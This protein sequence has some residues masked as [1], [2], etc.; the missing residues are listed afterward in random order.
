MF[1]EPQIPLNKRFWK[2]S[3]AERKA[4]EALFA[5]EGVR[6]RCLALAGLAPDD[7]VRVVDAA[8]W[9]KGCSS[10]G[11]LRY[12][13]LLGF[14]EDGDKRERHALVD[15]KEAVESVAPRKKGAKMPRDPAAR[16]V[17]GAC[18]LSPNLG[19]RMIPARLLGKPVVMRELAPQDL[20]IEIEQF[21]RAEAVQAAAYLAFIVGVAHARQLS[22]AERL[23]WA[24]KVTARREDNLDAPSW[25][26]NGIIEMAGAHEIG[27]LDH[28]RRYALSSAQ[29][30]QR[31]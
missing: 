12:A 10:L 20:K 27:Y 24:A 8:F 29:S 30:A 21:T 26:W 1:F 3:K 6:H 17:A 13:V 2:P 28:C 18:A 9:R 16:V 15:I 11:T 22:D 23:A 4:I 5:E 7:R 25:L 31:R 19:E 14:G